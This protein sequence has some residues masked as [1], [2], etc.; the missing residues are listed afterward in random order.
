MP[1]TA[2][3]YATIASAVYARGDADEIKRKITAE[4]DGKYN[5]NDYTIL[6]S[7]EDYVV[8]KKGDGSIIVGCRGTNGVDDIIPDIFISLGVLFLHPRA[9]KIFD[10]VHRYSTLHSNVTVTGH[11]LGGKLAALAA[12]NENVLAV[13][14]NQGSSPI[15]SNYGITKLQEKLYN[16]N[17]KNIIHF[18]TT[19][20][21]A[22]TSE[23]LLG[24]SHTIHV[25][26]PSSVNFLKNH[27]LTAFDGVNLDD[28]QYTNL[29]QQEGDRAIRD[30]RELDPMESLERSYYDTKAAVTAY[31]SLQ[32]LKESMPKMTDELDNMERYMNAEFDRYGIDPEEYST[33]EMEADSNA[34]VDAIVAAEEEKGVSEI[35]PS[36]FKYPYEFG[37]APEFGG[38]P[39]ELEGEIEGMPPDFE[40]KPFDPTSDPLQSRQP[41]EF[42]PEW[43]DPESKVSQSY[44]ERADEAMIEGEMDD[45]EIMRNITRD[46]NPD[47]M[48]PEQILIRLRQ[49]VEALEGV[50]DVTK[51]RYLL[52]IKGV[53]RVKSVSG[54]LESLGMPSLAN[55]LRSGYNRVLGLKG[56][57]VNK[58]PAWM[59]GPRM[60]KVGYGLG[61]VLETGMWIGM[62]A[63]AGYDVY[64]A[65]AQR[66][67]IKMLEKELYSEELSQYQ[68]KIRRQLRI[69]RGKKTVMDLE[70]GVHVGQLIM[71]TLATLAFPEF[72]PFVWVLI[73]AEQLSEI[74]IELNGAEIERREYLE[75]FY[76]SAERPN[77]W[78]YLN[79]RDDYEAKYNANQYGGVV[80][81]LG[82]VLGAMQNEL[83]KFTA[84]MPMQER[85]WLTM[86]GRNFY[87]DVDNIL[88]GE[89]PGLDDHRY[90]ELSNVKALNSKT[91]WR[92][93]LVLLANI[94]SQY[95]VMNNLDDYKVITNFGASVFANK[96]PTTLQE[97]RDVENYIAKK[98]RDMAQKQSH[99]DRY[100]GSGGKSQGD[101]ETDEDFTNRV[102]TWTR[103]QIK[104]ESLSTSLDQGRLFEEAG[105]GDSAYWHSRNGKVPMC[106]PGTRKRVLEVT[107][108]D[109]PKTKKN[110]FSAY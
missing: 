47:L 52:Q 110:I 55:T 68:F 81:W 107:D 27:Y 106:I 14:F 84:R 92:Q 30:K 62:I 95:T 61:K 6:E 26:P 94:G 50:S 82:W 23:S 59:K 9:K 31:N 66:S 97:Y 4:S 12:V 25:P 11:S 86:A 73:G 22:S 29:I 42:T 102:E 48:A 5:G 35:Y 78:T 75:E 39:P 10:V 54:A 15:D 17:F 109:P 56:A 77:I 100:M 16:Y 13:T 104:R 89:D 38:T 60:G 67:E 88:H 71:G 19:W 93:G 2:S 76:G 28:E 46:I 41:S 65:V 36:E 85:Y 7:T 45:I 63:F 103:E 98:K 90:E 34:I 8:V 21:G 37:E 3:E 49:N 53:E 20:D 101:D 40:A 69:E 83:K 99:V 91:A 18:T 87:N 79:K 108:F 24:S 43:M 32:S 1:T 70:A 72:A 105:R 74:P 64:N 80:D 33:P 51:Q 58:M 44:L 57:A 96:P